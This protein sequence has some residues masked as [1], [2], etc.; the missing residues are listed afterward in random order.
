MTVGLELFKDGRLHKYSQIL[1]AW[2]RSLP[3]RGPQLRVR[4]STLS[5]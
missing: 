5:A 1:I 2:A 4:Y 3:C